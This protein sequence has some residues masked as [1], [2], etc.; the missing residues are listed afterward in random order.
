MSTTRRKHRG[1][2]RLGFDHGNNVM[3]LFMLH[4]GLFLLSNP[5]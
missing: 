1:K 2:C 4:A 5:L 3:K